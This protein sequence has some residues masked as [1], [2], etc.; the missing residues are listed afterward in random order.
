MALNTVLNAAFTSNPNPPTTRY[1]KTSF[2][3][4]LRFVWDLK[5]HTETWRYPVTGTTKKGQGAAP[6][7]DQESMG[8]CI[9]AQGLGFLM[10]GGEAVADEDGAFVEWHR[11]FKASQGMKPKRSNSG[12]SRQRKA[13]FE[14][15]HVEAFY[16]H[17][18]AALETA[19]AAGQITGFQQGKQAPGGERGEG[20]IRRPKYSLSVPKAR[21]TGLAVA[22]FAWPRAES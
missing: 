11:N 14:P 20:R 13:S 4:S 5:A 6:L 1:G 9:E 18:P 2:D 16:F 7:N 19:K 17:T 22:R 21:G 3:Y 8:A 12:K 15:L 10:V